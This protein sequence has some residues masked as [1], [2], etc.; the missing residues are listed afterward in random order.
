[1][2]G[3]QLIKSA[4]F[5]EPVEH[6]PWVPFVGC[7]GG[8]LIGLDATTYLQS[9]EHIIRGVE[10][11]ILHYEP[12][13]IPILF[14]LQI[15]AE[16]LG[17]QLIWSKENPPFVQTHPLSEGLIFNDLKIPAPDAGRL[18]VVLEASRKV[19]KKYP[20]IAL[21]GL[22]T[23]PFTLG[24]HLLG[25]DL[26]IKM[27]EDS[28][29]VHQL[30]AFC[31][32]VCVTIADYYIEAGCDIIAL[33][34]PMTSQIGPEQ[35][36]TFISPFASDIFS[37]IKKRKKL[38]SFFVCGQAQ[39]NIEAMCECSPHNVSVDENIPLDYV[40]DICLNHNISFGGNL[41]LT[42]VLLLGKTEDVQQNVMECLELGGNKGYILSPGCDLPYA[43]PPENVKAVKDL[44]QSSYQ[45][46]VMHALRR[47]KVKSENLD[48]SDY[49]KTDR[50]IV[51]IITLDSEAC[52]PCQYMVEAVKKIAPQFENIVEWREH[53]IKHPESVQFMTSLMVKNIP[54]ICIDGKITFVS[55]IPPKEELVAAIQKRIF[56]KLNYKIRTKTGAIYLLG[57]NTKEINKIKSL[58]E[59]AK[60]ELGSKLPIFEIMEKNEILSYGV[61]HTPAIVIAQYKVKSE[62]TIPS[63]AAIKEWI[64]DI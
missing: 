53:K 41:Q 3:L 26:F 44:L 50:V 9:S 52:A 15:E 42:V 61:L 60:N 28:K 47:E 17:C 12:D 22:V 31:R 27:V 37:H 36:R 64:K 6:V 48:M 54:T 23:G 59:K 13:G 5:L 8:A 35:F 25:T 51:D 63:V 30:M 32:D 24:M 4:F 11:A 43:T 2:T 62:K 58:V 38:S 16:A 33:V 34:D 19:K 39:Q 45:Q 49:G 10:A 55:K 14:D 1:M 56:E 46:Q 20:E 7:H 40:R 57:N 21:Y 18:P 29:Y